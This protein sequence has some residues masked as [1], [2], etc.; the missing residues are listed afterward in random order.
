MKV[1]NVK[2]DSRSDLSEYDQ[3]WKVH[4][5]LQAAQYDFTT[6]EETTGLIIDGNSL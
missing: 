1:R 4:K 5:S 3:I 2:T 6:A